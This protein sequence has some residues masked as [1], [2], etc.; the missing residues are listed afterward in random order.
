MIFLFCD[1]IFGAMRKYDN[2]DDNRD[3]YRNE[4]GKDGNNAAAV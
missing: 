3:K 4:D 1:K 2:K